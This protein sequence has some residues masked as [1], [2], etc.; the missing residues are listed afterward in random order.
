ERNVWRRDES[1]CIA[2]KRTG[3]CHVRRRRK[4]RSWLLPSGATCNHE[5]EDVHAITDGERRAETLDERARFRGDEADGRRRAGGAGGGLPARRA[6][7]R[8]ARSTA[9]LRESPTASTAPARSAPRWKGPNS[10][11]GSR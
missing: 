10:C 9:F 3:A 5:P 2:P 11:P 6:A 1:S 8:R 7:A 4:D